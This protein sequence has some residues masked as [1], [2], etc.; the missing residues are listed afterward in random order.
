MGIK[1]AGLAIS[2][3]SSGRCNSSAHRLFG[4]RDNVVAGQTD[5]VLNVSHSFG[6]HSRRKIL[7]SPLTGSAARVKMIN[8]RKDSIM[9]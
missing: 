9:E 4:T 1:R 8:F 3:G 6:L 2:Q 7:N 5:R